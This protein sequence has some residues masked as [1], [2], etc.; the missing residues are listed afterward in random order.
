M[1]WLTVDSTE[2][3][4]QLS[5]VRYE[6][7]TK[8]RRVFSGK[9]ATARATSAGAARVWSF[10]T[11][12]LERT[13]ADALSAALRAPGTVSAAGDVIGSTVTCVGVVTN[14]A[15]FLEDLVTV[16]FELWEETA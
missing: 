16:S 14:E 11:D 12:L 6:D 4:V 10:Q 7:L 1:A 5:G 13:S 8:R 3:A 9:Q 15:E 2:Y